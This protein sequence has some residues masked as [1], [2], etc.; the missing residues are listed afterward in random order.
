VYVEEPS[1]W[2]ERG[3]I[4]GGGPVLA[5]NRIIPLDLRGVRGSLLRIRIRPPAGSWALNSFAV[6]YSG[7]R[8]VSVDK[9]A[10]STARD[11]TGKDVLA[12][13]LG[14]D[15]RYYAMPTTADRGSNGC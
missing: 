13:L 9:I 12:D 5:P 8:E 2:V 6:D 1:G 7:D 4:P 14:G 3:V 10:P 11:H 15:S